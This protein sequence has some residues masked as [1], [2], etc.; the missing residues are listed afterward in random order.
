M[1]YA[2]DLFADV[3]RKDAALFAKYLAD[4][5]VFRFA[6]ADEVIGRDNIET[7]LGAFYDSI[8]ALS[9]ERQGLYEVD[10]SS[11]VWSDVTYTKFDDS[12]LTVP[13]VTIVKRNDDGLIVDYR[14]F[15]DAT[16]LFA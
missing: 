16:P 13:V 2:D 9:H 12:R 7:A 5:A 4:D 8:K 11:V 15:M 1:S 6:N 10:D 3:D 14:I